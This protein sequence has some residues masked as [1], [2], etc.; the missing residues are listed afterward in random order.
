MTNKVTQMI[1]K[2]N[3][4]FKEK[5]SFFDLPDDRIDLIL[6]IDG[7]SESP[8]EYKEKIAHQWKSTIDGINQD[9]GTSYEYPESLQCLLIEVNAY[10]ALKEE[11]TPDTQSPSEFLEEL[12]QI[13]DE[14]E[15]S[16]E[17]EYVYEDEYGGYDGYDEKHGVYYTYGEDGRKYDETGLI[18]PDDVPVV[19]PSRYTR[20]FQEME[21]ARIIAEQ[22]AAAWSKEE[23]KLIKELKKEERKN[24]RGGGFLKGAAITAGTAYVSY[25][26]G[27]KIGKSLM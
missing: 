6:A 12:F 11:T 10:N 13:M 5:T 22:E 3:K 1:E 25:K 9:L 27:N 18:I 4:D 23:A 20:E 16:E 24:R 8:S 21:R 7:I 26:I 15:N 19:N 14:R 2:I 17:N